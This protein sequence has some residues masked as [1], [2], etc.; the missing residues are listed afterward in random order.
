MPINP[1]TLEQM[2]NQYNADT[3]SDGA[4][5][6]K[7]PFLLGDANATLKDVGGSFGSD[8]QDYRAG[9]QGGLEKVGIGLTRL[10]LQT[11]AKTIQ[12]AGYLLGLGQGLLTNGFNEEALVAAADN[13]IAK[14]GENLDTDI[15]DYLTL[16]NTKAD[17]NGNL[18]SRLGDADFWAGDFVDG[19]A[20][21][22]SAYLTGNGLGSLG[23]GLK[24]AKAFASLRGGA[25]LMGKAGI[26]GTGL[27]RGIDL[28]VNTAIQTASESM[29]E[30]K[31]VLDSSRQT[32][33]K[34]KFGMDY[35]ALDDEGKAIVNSE[36]GEI[37]AGAFRDNAAL[38]ILPNLWE[39]SIFLKKG[40][41]S[42]TPK[43][44][45]GDALST[46][47]DGATSW[48][49]KK[50]E[51]KAGEYAKNIGKG[52][53]A[54]GLFE[55]NLQFGVQKIQEHNASEGKT[56]GFFEDLV[57]PELYSSAL[58][59]KEGRE[60][61]LIGAL[62][63]AGG[64]AY[65]A[66]RERTGK[67]KYLNGYTDKDGNRVSGIKEI[68]DIPLNNGIKGLT[69]I[70]QTQEVEVTDPDTGEITKKQEPILDENNKRIIDETKLKN[71]LGQHK[72]YEDLLDLSTLAQENGNTTIADLARNQAFGKWAQAHFENEQGDLLREKVKSLGN[73]SDTE[74]IAQGLDP[75][76][77]RQHVADLMNQLD[78][79]EQI[80]KTVKT[81]VMPDANTAKQLGIYESRKKELYNLGTLL[82]NLSTQKVKL[83]Q[84]ATKLEAELGAQYGDPANFKGTKK[85]ALDMTRMKI[86][87]LS[88]MEEKVSSKFDYFSDVKEG[89]KRFNK[90]IESIINKK[91]TSF[92][93]L[94]GTRKDF[95]SWLSTNE[96]NETIK[97]KAKNISA[98]LTQESITE[99]LNE[100]KSPA[101]VAKSVIDVGED[102]PFESFNEI[103]QK[104]NDDKEAI[105]SEVNDLVM[106]DAFYTTQIPEGDRTPEEQVQAERIET[107][108]G[109]L[110]EYGLGL[111]AVNNIRGALEDK[112]D[113][114]Y[115]EMPAFDKSDEN[116]DNIKRELI[117]K[118]T[119]NID[120]VLEAYNINPD[121][122]NINAIEKEIGRAKNLIIAID[123]DYPDIVADLK[124]K[125]AELQA[126]QIEVE[127]R[128]QDRE[129]MQRVILENELSSM[130]S[131]LG[132]DN[133]NEVIDSE[134]NQI[135]LETIE[136]PLSDIPKITTT[137]GKR[138]NFWSRFGRLEYLMSLLRQNITNAT[139]ARLT[140]ILD[141]KYLGL[142]ELQIVKNA[143]AFGLSDMAVSNF[144]DNL[145][146]SL[147]MYK[148]N[149]DSGLYSFISRIRGGSEGLDV[150]HDSAVATFLRTRNLA[151]FEEMVKTEERGDS[152]ITTKELLDLI[153]FHKE[154][155]GLNNLLL[156]VESKYNTL[157]EVVKE[158]ENSKGQ[159]IL[160]TYQQL[161]AIRNILKFLSSPPREG[162]Y[163]QF[164][165]QKGF[166][167][168]GKTTI[169]AKWV[170]KSLGYGPTE[171]LATG[172]TESSS[173]LINQQFGINANPT[174]EQITE[175][176][177]SDSI[178]T[179]KVIIIDE[180]SG[181]TKDE[182]D[183]VVTAL[184]NYNTRNKTDIKILGLGDPNQMTP[185]GLSKNFFEDYRNVDEYGSMTILPPLT[186]RYRSDIGPVND[187]QDLFLGRVKSIVNSPIKVKT[188]SDKSLGVNGAISPE[189]ITAELESRSPGTTKLIIVNEKDVDAFKT[190]FPN[191]EVVS[192]NNAQGRTVE[193]AF[194][195]LSPQDYS[196]IQ[197]FN[198][199]M[200][201]AASRA[202]K[203]LFVTGIPITPVIDDSIGEVSKF[204]AESLKKGI[205]LFKE[206][207]IEEKNQY[208]EDFVGPEKSEEDEIVP[209]IEDTEEE[210]ED[211]ENP[212]P[213]NE[214][215]TEPSEEEPTITEVD[216]EEVITPEEEF[217]EEEVIVEED[218]DNP[219]DVI[220]GDPETLEDDSVGNMVNLEDLTAEEFKEIQ[221]GNRLSNHEISLEGITS[222]NIPKD[223]SINGR[224]GFLI[225]EKILSPKAGIDGHI[226]VLVPVGNGTYYKV[227]V[228]TSKEL[229]D[230]KNPYN[231][232][233]GHLVSRLKDPNSK[234]HILV[235][236]DNGPAKPKTYQIADGSDVITASE[237]TFIVN[238][239][240]PL[241]YFYDFSKLTK[242][243]KSA[244]IKKFRQGLKLDPKENLKKENI[245]VF[246]RAMI[247]E[248][249][250]FKGIPLKA[251]V[252]YLR[253]QT[254]GRKDQFIRLSRKVLNIKTHAN[255]MMPIVNYVK[256]Y[257]ALK[258]LL[259]GV[260]V[261]V[262]N[263]FIT[264]YPEGEMGKKSMEFREA[265]MKKYLGPKFKFTN[266]MITL[267][268]LIRDGYITQKPT[269]SIGD[270]VQLKVGSFSK[271]NKKG[272]VVPTSG[273]VT[274]I[275]G[276]RKNGDY[277]IHVGD[278]TYLPEALNNIETINGP[279]AQQ[280]NYIIRANNI[281][282]GKT[283]YSSIE[284]GKSKYNANTAF[285][286]PLLPN[287]NTD[288]FTNEEK[289][290]IMFVDN[291]VI[292]Q[293]KSSNI[294]HLVSE[295][296]KK[297]PLAKNQFTAEQLANLDFPIPFFW[298]VYQDSLTIK[299]RE[300]NKITLEFLEEF[301]TTD[302]KGNLVTSVE[303]RM[304]AFVPIKLKDYPLNPVSDE[305]KQ[306]DRMEAAERGE[307]Y[308]EETAPDLLFQSYD[309]EITPAL[310]TITD[311]E[312]KESKN[313]PT[314][315]E[316]PAPDNSGTDFDNSLDDYDFG[317]TEE[318][319]GVTKGNLISVDKA[320]K[321]IQKQNPGMSA[322]K[323]QV[324][325]R[326]AFEAELGYVNFGHYKKGIIYLLEVAPGQ[327]Y[328][329]V[330]RHEAFHHTYNSAFT[331]EQRN[332]IEKKA[333]KEWG[334]AA[335]MEELLANKFQ[336]WRAGSP[337][338]SFFRTVFEK[339]ANLLGFQLKLFSDFDY[340]FKAISTGQLSGTQDTSLTDMP[341]TEAISDFGSVTLYEFAQNLMSV[342][343]NKQYVENNKKAFTTSTIV[344]NG[345]TK[346]VVPRSLTDAFAVIR[347]SILN[348]K[349][350]AFPDVYQAKIT[351]AINKK[352]VEAT[353]GVGNTIFNLISNFKFSTE[354][355]S[356]SKDLSVSKINPNFILDKES[357]EDS[358]TLGDFFR[359]YKASIEGEDKSQ[360]T[361][362]E[363]R[364]WAVLAL[365]SANKE[366]FI[367]RAL[368]T[369][370]Y[371]K[372]SD[373]E[374]AAYERELEENKASK[375]IAISLKITQLKKIFGDEANGVNVW[376]R[377]IRNLYPDSI[378]L[379]TDW[380]TDQA[381]SEINHQKNLTA[382]VK[383]FM[384][385][386][387]R[388]I[389]VDGKLKPKQ[390]NPKYAYLRYIQAMAGVST[391][392]LRTMLSEIEKS[393]LGTKVKL[394]QD[395]LALNQTIISLVN[396]LNSDIDGISRSAQ[397]Q[398]ILSE[399]KDYVDN[400]YGINAQTLVQELQEEF[401]LT[402][403]GAN[404]VYLQVMNANT[405]RELMTQLNSLYEQ[406]VHS[407]IY[408]KTFDKHTAK[409]K[410]AKSNSEQVLDINN[411]KSSIE[412]RW[413]EFVS[414]GLNESILKVLEGKASLKEKY[415]A[416][417]KFVTF[418]LPGK[419]LQEFTEADNLPLAI[420]NMLSS[421]NSEVG[422][423]VPKSKEDSIEDE[424]KVLTPFEIL[425]DHTNN[426]NLLVSSF[427][428]I[429]SE[430]KASSYINGA[431]KPSF[432]FTL[433]SYA[434]NSIIRFTKKALG[435]HKPAFAK[436]P[437]YK[438]N[439]YTKDN[440]IGVIKNYVNYDSA[441]S[442]QK[443]FD[444]IVYKDENPMQWLE[445]NFVGMF[446]AAITGMGKETDKKLKNL[447]Y[448]QQ[449]YTPSNKSDIL[450]ANVK[451][452]NQA[453][454]N[455]AILSAVQIMKDKRNGTIN[456]SSVG[457]KSDFDYFQIESTDPASNFK[458]DFENK[459]DKEILDQVNEMFARE[460]KKLVSLMRK[461]NAFDK[462][463][464]SRYLEFNQLNA[465][466]SLL[467]VTAESSEDKFEGVVTAFYKN[468]FIQSLFLN[469]LVVGDQSFFASEQDEIK[470]V[471][472]AFGIGHRPFV[473]SEWG[474]DEHFHTI[475]GEDIKKVF[476]SDDYEKFKSVIGNLYNITDGQGFITPRRAEQIRKAFGKGLNLKGIF[477]PIYYA[478]EET[479]GIPRALK[480]SSVELT[481][482]LVKM[483]PALKILLDKMERVEA[484]TNT[485][486]E[487][488][489]KSGMKVGA[490]KVLSTDV[491]GDTPFAPESIIKMDNY[492]YR[493]Q[494]NPHHELGGSTTAMPIQLSYFVDFSGKLE[495]IADRMYKATA[496]LIQKGKV[497]FLQSE[498]L[499]RNANKDDMFD[500]IS[501]RNLTKTFVNSLKEERDA[502]TRS[503]ANHP[504]LGINLP[505][506][507]KKF[508][509]SLSSALSK[510]TVEIRI[511]GGSA[512]LQ[513]A[514]GTTTKFIDENGVEQN[515]ELQWRNKDGY[516][517]VVLTGDFKGRV[518]AGDIILYDK[519]LGF[520]VPTTELHSAI[521]MKVVGFYPSE[522]PM[523]IAPGEITLFHG[524][525]Y[526]IDK[527]SILRFSSY[528]LSEQ[529]SDNESIL[530]SQNW[531]VGRDADNIPIPNF[532]K[533]LNNK[534][535]QIR[536]MIAGSS[537]SNPLR[538][539]YSKL[540]KAETS[541]LNNEIVDSLLHAVTSED[542]TI[543]HI[544]NQPISMERFNG[545]TKEGQQESV[546]DYL[547]RLEGFTE[548]APIK[549]DSETAEE[550]QNRVGD[551]ID[552]RNKA[553]IYKKINLNSVIDQMNVHK[554]SFIGTQLTGTF[555]NFVKA[556][557]YLFKSDKDAKWALP[558]LGSKVWLSVGNTIYKSFAYEENVLEKAA[559][560]AVNEQLKDVYYTPETA[561]SLINAAIDNVKEQILN[562]INFNKV[563]GKVA[564]SMLFTGIPLNT[565]VLMMK[566]QIALDIS[567]SNSFRNGVKDAFK[568]L[569]TE[570]RKGELPIVP[571][572]FNFKKYSTG[573]E[574]LQA[575]QNWQPGD[576]TN[577]LAVI[578]E[579]LEE[580]YKKVVAGKG[581]EEFT[582][583]ELMEQYK[584][585]QILKRA[586]KTA[587]VVSNFS[588]F[589]GLQKSLPVEYPALVKVI[590]A[591]DSLTGFDSEKE[592]A[593]PYEQMVEDDAPE[594]EEESIDLTEDP[595]K[596]NE[597][598]VEDIDIVTNDGVFPN[599]DFLKLPHIAE[600][601]K[602]A[603][604]LKSKI[605]HSL[606]LHN[607]KIARFINSVYT[608][609]GMSNKNIEQNIQKFKE[610]FITYVLT[611]V[612]YQ[613]PML[614]KAAK[615][616]VAEGKN[617]FVTYSIDKTNY[618][619]GES[620]GV[621]GWT[622]D[623]IAEIQKLKKAYPKN[624][625]LKNL[626]VDKKGNVKFLTMDT[627]GIEFNTVQKLREHFKAIQPL[628]TEPSEEFNEIQN[629]LLIYSIIKNGLNFGSNNYSSV[630]PPEL[631]VPF[632]TEYDSLLR[633]LLK[634]GAEINLQNFLNNIGNYFE[635]QQSVLQGAILP[636]V[637]LKNSETFTGK[638]NVVSKDKLGD[639]FYDL[640]LTLKEKF[641]KLDTVEKIA[642]KFK[643]YILIGS[644]SVYKLVKIEENKGI[645]I[646]LGTAGVGLFTNPIDLRIK[647]NGYQI[648]NYVN[649][650]VPTIRGI[651]PPK[652]VISGVKSS[653]KL[654]VGQPVIYQHNT[655]IGGVKSKKMIVSK[656]NE[657]SYVLVE[658]QSSK[659]SFEDWN[660]KHGNP[661][662]SIE[663]NYNF[664]LKCHF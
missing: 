44:K 366:E 301:I 645:Y 472:I 178:G 129:R 640:V 237:G 154:Y 621:V 307:E 232:V 398:Q 95:Q 173:T 296:F 184:N 110:S 96:F 186:I 437:L 71:V 149:P 324:L 274:N 503:F 253:I 546:F 517:E 233:F 431:G 538:K 15:K 524:S 289:K 534:I 54:E 248:E 529:I 150:Q 365:T 133:E 340:L 18:L 260:P 255:V 57:N 123:T 78:A 379:N 454:I 545:A 623:F 346:L 16:Y 355:L 157:A 81:L 459:T 358:D 250:Q 196:D 650:A 368:E 314:K 38:L 375:N 497:E 628:D 69:D 374:F 416:A 482:E 443:T 269:I 125:L 321:L 407:V 56:S 397:D 244:I 293:A 319:T 147:E 256:N 41:H 656:V 50:L 484:E 552:R 611:G 138:G 240:Q 49:G 434:V 169:V 579:I 88:K 539:T 493:M 614:E 205:E 83:G 410:V 185:G 87:E 291:G 500:N 582:P 440:P 622:Q 382:S 309:F 418:F 134:L 39:S 238:N 177:N 343:L 549:L 403:L 468:F 489:F 450:S 113:K 498:G 583:A 435:N 86:D 480:Y 449:F 427:E 624:L 311:V 98:Q 417:Q 632:Y 567:D 380:T 212:P 203:Y 33:S 201:T 456:F 591:I 46:V 658:K 630:L 429:F 494:Q 58:S 116:P 171:I 565:V 26:S 485:A 241:M 67:D 89:N 76:E 578:P 660:A 505:L 1:S 475:V 92:N 352:R 109:K 132:I 570:L 526:D 647:E 530:L 280:W 548:P 326:A 506:M 571:K 608:N 452:L 627:A 286:A 384:S 519:L 521:P 234:R 226:S 393:L 8:L 504:G 652:G 120:A 491:L 633:T 597:E 345:V 396:Q 661:S 245:V 213:T 180:V 648:D 625:F 105:V 421:L 560:D 142:A 322:D 501:L 66:H 473:N 446:S 4:L 84:E 214:P 615:A 334:P 277:L 70:Y 60:S 207:R 381:D 215:P 387:Y 183:S 514:F 513:S 655:D 386:I 290:N 242:F 106:N 153:K 593:S 423:I 638:F 328:E 220:Q 219:I 617:P 651:F 400:N 176:L 273:K 192:V 542:E 74:M 347:N 270:R 104:L 202:S 337:I 259:P 428:S 325:N 610:D 478:I 102:I 574:A 188:N 252:P 217:E 436:T 34:R 175:K 433:S 268:N 111:E 36:A 37:A 390:I 359:Y 527:L 643:P 152:D 31:G 216:V 312:I 100:G 276:S 353:E 227:A 266:K 64:G 442:K 463:F 17:E 425:D 406:N 563:T 465:L 605:E 75:K 230:P 51:S 518:K 414:A 30:A 556:T 228:L 127:K 336:E 395:D 568:L 561:D 161:I 541:Y 370:S 170:M 91:K 182:F 528:K 350:E 261:K 283:V 544:M 444:A 23:L 572:T 258:D 55:E 654:E 426:L 82:N 613:V 392:N 490:P 13:S 275:T 564:L 411:V 77:M 509:T 351:A 278:A 210:E 586:N 477:K 93:S 408:D 422:T 362:H 294:K 483:F 553:V 466:S 453:E 474:M 555:A 438:H 369:V 164:V 458:L 285:Y 119:D 547:A 492:N 79:Y 135:V 551:F 131:G 637:T 137:D 371:P 198:T 148:D 302:S 297:N 512:V 507:H 190:K 455:Q 128:L 85:V 107:I 441:I 448:N 634:P 97:R 130:S 72:I 21:L 144:T 349:D 329:N 569:N 42:T 249:T 300:E 496:R 126:A 642:D 364:D 200:Y 663:S 59:S 488:V 112:I 413:P 63:G 471:S 590:K 439:I 303:G 159:L 208:P 292:S 35:D 378:A 584:L 516:A 145:N 204:Q 399:A 330:A 540:L 304:P 231:K 323:I 619:N 576:A 641:D 327:V 620:T 600:A 457:F 62:L 609:L 99:G 412:N 618:V 187:F 532:E 476:T 143:K 265:E 156:F 48:L 636:K 402:P 310:V 194:I 318:Q 339:I 2:V 179:A 588:L 598:V 19:A 464:Y 218:V 580:A 511:P 432:F 554:S 372:M 14:F 235:A 338:S 94:T 224:R 47:E 52:I 295:Y 566:Q 140:S 419:I 165:F 43:L 573:A 32:I 385:T 146:S 599:I 172:H 594:V 239:A 3:S 317:Y 631:L 331:K 73:M 320:I 284:S 629:N 12:G 193:E 479:T 209:P 257:R 430:A 558:A 315:P 20:F 606:F 115:D 607:K 299:N 158:E 510:A 391:K 467:G 103:I 367:N 221:E 223:T 537:L 243:V 354:Y 136:T 9:Q 262:I 279:A 118:H 162:L 333:A 662:K 486:T 575:A 308:K 595:L 389:E 596:G 577:S 305:Q 168:T 25:A 424:D 447:F 664:Y 195:Y 65:G 635:L 246:T 229:T 101:Y 409:I 10:P 508:I 356:K 626:K 27:A 562:I 587:N 415:E 53:L 267:K 316:G 481:P 520:R 376:N 191:H 451:Y 592:D 7:T 361:N 24:G 335:N 29:F 377:F 80:Y 160:P 461:K 155:V 313:P 383:L 363:I 405:L 141:K 603:V 28:G 462:S 499:T 602:V 121:Y 251:G 550:F 502:I 639:K 525:D 585:L 281:I 357:T 533:R 535:K 348:K 420:A 523:I 166:A 589:L 206:E 373:A 543:Q 225:F 536:D 163:R 174:V 360:L 616:A 394:S 470:R 601:L 22:A 139:I 282:N 287:A 515:R 68:L 288:D 344:E 404:Q 263:D 388:N 342:E 272:E 61:M 90:Q 197:D 657:N 649:L 460:A 199:A 236:N 5:F 659:I 264:T 306:A 189:A 40:Y 114:F 122:D 653:Y 646:K 644:K 6:D 211:D 181:L 222:D 298:K 124:T 522:S 581:Y 247:A 11:A 151:K 254:E 108:I 167:G 495:S 117:K 332:L 531:I 469:Q 557:A 604:T 487:F 271:T 445:R 612:T 341:Y 559:A 401:G 45:M